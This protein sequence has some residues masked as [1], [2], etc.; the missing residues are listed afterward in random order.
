M[1]GGVLP[2]GPCHVEGDLPATLRPHVTPVHNYKQ[3]VQ[4]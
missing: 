1:K 3:C 4:L 2:G